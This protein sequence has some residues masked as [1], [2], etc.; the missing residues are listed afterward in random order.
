[1]FPIV[2]SCTDA[3]GLIGLQQKVAQ[4]RVAEALLDYLQALLEYAP[5]RAACRAGLSPRAGL[6]LQ[7]CAR[8]GR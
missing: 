5:P 6:A 3:A 8:P 7:Q 4:V 1:M 2:P